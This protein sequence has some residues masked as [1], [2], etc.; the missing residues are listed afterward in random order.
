ME[1]MYTLLAQ[2]DMTKFKS[3]L[4]RREIHE[5][6]LRFVIYHIAFHGN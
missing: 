3:I 4:A 1:K 5:G 2:P 6:F